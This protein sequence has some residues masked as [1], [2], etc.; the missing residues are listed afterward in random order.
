M[1]RSVAA[2]VSL[3]PHSAA[4]EHGVRCCWL[5]SMLLLL[6]VVA[7]VVVFESRLSR[8]QTVGALALQS[9]ALIKYR[10][11]V[12][13]TMSDTASSCS[14]HAAL[15]V[16]V[17]PMSGTRRSRGDAT[18]CGGSHA[19]QP[20]QRRSYGGIFQHHASHIQTATGRYR[21]HCYPIWWS[22]VP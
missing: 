1:V 17:L 14:E 20:S 18:R 19:H 12:F 2:A 7:V 9:T 10:L 22:I 16:L 11:E 8:F 6:L 13:R 4:F 5:L 21:T 3:P 15:L